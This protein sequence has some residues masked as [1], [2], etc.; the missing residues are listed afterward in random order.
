MPA[1]SLLGIYTREMETCPCKDLYT[2][3]HSRFIY[4]RQ[5]LKTTQSPKDK[6]V[7]SKVTYNHIM[8][9]HSAIKNKQITDR[10]N[11]DDS[12]KHYAK[13]IRQM[14]KSTCCMISF[15]LNSRKSKTDIYRKQIS[16]GLGLKGDTGAFW[17]IIIFY[18]LIVIV[19]T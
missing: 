10:H 14:Q 13:W 12:Q 2:D 3:V 5:K 7:V 15:K 11:M 4:S 6:W 19:I 16:G 9:T 18:T 17:D 1:I 8:K